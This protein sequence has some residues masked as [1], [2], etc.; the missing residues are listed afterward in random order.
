MVDAKR[1]VKKAARK[2]KKAGRQLAQKTEEAV[3]EAVGKVKKEIPKVRRT[4]GESIEE[5][6][7]SI[8][9]DSEYR[10]GDKKP[11]DL[12]LY[13]A[14]C[15]KC[16]SKFKTAYEPISGLSIY[17]KNCSSEPMPGRH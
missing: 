7:R 11:G 16:G 2:I 8:K 4:V 15:S 17:C 9:E 10:G 14:T 13:E 12:G 1:A 3:D 5:V 6:G